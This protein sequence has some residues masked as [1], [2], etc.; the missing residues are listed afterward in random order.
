M[1]VTIF[2]IYTSI[3]GTLMVHIGMTLQ[4]QYCDGVIS[5]T[6]ALSI[7]FIVGNISFKFM[8]R[9][10]PKAEGF[11]NTEQWDLEALNKF[12]YGQM[13]SLKIPEMSGSD[14]DRW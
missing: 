10:K 8:K 11:T 14:L 4:A 9:P 3:W 1:E 13:T 6:Y 2:F 5:V 7:V 12:T